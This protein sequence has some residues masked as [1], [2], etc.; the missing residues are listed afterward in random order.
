MKHLRKYRF[1][2]YLLT[3]C[4]VLFGSLLIPEPAFGRWVSPLTLNLNLAA[5]FV[6]ISTRRKALWSYAAIFAFGMLLYLARLLY[7]EDPGGSL[8]LVRLAFYAAF[9]ILVT[10]EIILQ[11][12]QAKDVNHKVIF[13]LISGYISLGLVAFFMVVFIEITHPGS[14]SGLPENPDFGTLS[15]AL[16]YY[17]YITLMTIGYGDMAPLNPLARKAAVL[18]GLL[19]QFYL[20]IITAVVVEKY[21]AARKDT[22]PPAR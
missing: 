1:E 10:V 8:Q 15:E 22:P 19:G 5:G 3:A 9:Y 17:A 21:I 16:L 11:V 4:M 18:I 13:G 20:V 7:R 12:W 6:L 14:F 2:V